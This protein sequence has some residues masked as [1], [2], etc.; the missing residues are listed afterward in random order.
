ADS[1]ADTDVTDTASSGGPTAETGV[2]E[3]CGTDVG[4]VTALRVT[5]PF[6]PHEARLEV[7][8]SVAS[9]VAVACVLDGDPSEV[10][11]VEDA[12]AGTSHRLSMGGLLADAD[13]T[14]TARTVCPETPDRATAAMST[15][16]P[17]SRAP[18][19][20]VRVDRAARGDEY[21]V[22]HLTQACFTQSDL[23]LVYDRDG[24]PRFRYDLP[25]SPGISIEFRYLGDD[26]FSWGGGW[27]PTQYGRPRV[28]DL[29]RGELYDSGVG[30]PD[31]AT[32]LFHHDGYVMP[33]GRV[34]TLEEERVQGRQGT[35]RGFRVRRLDPTTN[36]VDFDYHSQRAFDEG[37]LPGGSGDVWHANAVQIREVAG[38]EV[39]YVSLC[40]AQ[41][42]AAIDVAT[43]N[44]R[45]TF[46]QGEDFSVVDTAGRP[47]TNAPFPACQ[48]G[49]ETDGQT[50]LV[51][52]NGVNR[53]SSRVAEYSLDESTHVA[54]LNWTWTEPDWYETTMGDVEYLPSGHVLVT[55]AHGE[56]FS[57]NRGDVTT[58]VEIDP[59]TG[60]K[61]WDARYPVPNDMAYR[62]DWADA[63]ALF[64]NAKYC[65]TVRDRLADLSLP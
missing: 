5:H 40:N 51:Y 45:W 34:L 19:L 60:N 12:V 21:L 31:L 22:T 62:G 2:L 33:D 41:K 57:S 8:T 42:I 58:F 43:G 14:C 23:A 18:D 13:Y 65:S 49:P 15:P 63:C 25:L 3:P 27:D 61:L 10:H 54:T 37:H 48:H 35:F 11:L 36:T 7:D 6:G 44:W 52:D 64:A 24:R 17:S 55:M 59:V 26:K 32:S 9:S 56:C 20:D 4:G 46:G 47:V 28:I 30:F 1:D 39:L 16:N 29:Y 53:G 38:Q 50:L